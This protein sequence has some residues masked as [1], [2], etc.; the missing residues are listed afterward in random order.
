MGIIPKHVDIT[1][2]SAWLAEEKPS[3][4]QESV[5]IVDLFDFVM[6]CLIFF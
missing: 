3:V 1:L 5:M 4:I 2:I 6:I